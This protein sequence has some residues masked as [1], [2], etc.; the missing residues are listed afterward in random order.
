MD[1]SMSNLARLKPDPVPAIRPVPERL[2]TGPLAEA[3]ARTKSGLNVPWMG[4]VAMA[5]A[6][7]PRFYARLWSALEPVARSADFTRACAA[8]RAAAEAEA[9]GLSPQP[10]G[11]GL[12]DLGYDA[13][14]LGEIRACNEVFSEGNMPY[15]LM[16]SLARSL[17][18]GTAW[19][20]SAVPSEHAERK[21]GAPRP[22]LMEEHHA[23]PTTRAIY[24]DI[25]GALGL[26]FVN[27][28]YRAFGRWPSYLALAWPDL[29]AA[30]TG[31]EYE[32]RVTRVHHRAVDLALGLPNATGLSSKDLIVAAEADASAAEVLEV[33]RLFQW[34]LP[35]LALN[36][37]FMRAQLLDDTREA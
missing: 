22:A 28:D 2:A 11:K 12:R 31:S 14:E 17:L 19:D 37:A 9:D 5:F 27:T 7:Y 36:V 4:V 35:G 6:Y 20:G 21:P 18:E 29:K 26:A 3:Y 33:V 13:R 25:R 8:L 1:R 16:A 15:V 34:L 30:V 10:L 23:D 24:A 32:A